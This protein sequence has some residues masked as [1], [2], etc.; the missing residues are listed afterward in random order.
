MNTFETE[1]KA[2]SP[3]QSAISASSSL[4]FPR[5]PSPGPDQAL[6]SPIYTTPNR[7]N[8]LRY[9]RPRA[10]VPESVGAPSPSPNSPVITVTD[11]AFD[12]VFPSNIKRKR[13]GREHFDRSLEKVLS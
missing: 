13:S 6:L 1:L 3:A 8:Y 2:S 9:G 7:P 4:L 5:T 10:D 12:S 11:E